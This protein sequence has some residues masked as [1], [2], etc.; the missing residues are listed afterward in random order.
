MPLPPIDPIVLGCWQLAEGH[1]HEVEERPAVLEAYLEAGFRAFDVADIYTG[2]EALL[3]EV[4][5][6]HGASDAVRVHTKLVPD[7]AELPL[8]GSD[9]VRRMI[10]RS[11]KRL[12]K[13]RLELVQFHWWDNAVP[14]ALKVLETLQSLRDEGAIAGIGVTNFA[15]TDLADFAA[16][17]I[18]IDSVQVQVSLIDRR[19]RGA[20]SEL[21]AEH[22]IDLLAYGSVAGGLLRE[23]WL[24]Q[25]A[26]AEPH[27]NRS[28][29]K[30]LLMVR[31]LGG[32]GALQD[33]LRALDTV[34]RRHASDV[35]S[36]ASAW[37]LAQP[38]VRAA[39]VGIRSRRHL[40]RHSALRRGFTL[41]PED[42]AAL[43][44]VR[45]RYPEIPGPVYA[46]ERDRSGPHGRIM[47]YG[48]Q[49]AGGA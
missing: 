17:G 26:P 36:V 6:A 22:G 44:A 7:L 3:G 48:L 13:E 21:A 37:V 2:V 20:F 5:A 1:G 11:R 47:K 49:E 19:S 34:A 15:A 16:E 38:G 4:L 43:E 31:E 42:V 30:Y 12:R 41:E 25:D 8:L 14:G 32:W 33:L 39:V 9:D 29:T 10:D 27:E 23:A 46:L 24:D 45:R 28:L 35:A 18:P 40:A